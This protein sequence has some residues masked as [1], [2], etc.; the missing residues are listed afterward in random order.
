[1]THLDEVRYRILR[2]LDRNPHMSQRELARELSISLG[3][4]NYC[5]RAVI[6]RGWVKAK[7]LPGGGSKRGYAYFLTPKGLEE[8]AKVAARF[9]KH[10]MA[11]YENIEKEIEQL[12]REA[13]QD[14]ARHGRRDA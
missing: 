5:L 2:A 9:L 14:S 8:K 1:M 11:E 6:T 7:T 12:R 10:K 3:K 4:I 13:A